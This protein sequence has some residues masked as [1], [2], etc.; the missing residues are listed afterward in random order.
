MPP[1]RKRTVR[2]KNTPGSRRRTKRKTQNSFSNDIR[3]RGSSLATSLVKSQRIPRQRRGNPSRP[4]VRLRPGLPTNIFVNYDKNVLDKR[5]LLEHHIAAGDIDPD[6]VENSSENDEDGLGTDIFKKYVD[7]AGGP[8]FKAETEMLRKHQECLRLSQQNRALCAERQQIALDSELEI[9]PIEVERNDFPKHNNFDNIPSHPYRTIFT[10]TTGSGK[11]TNMINLLIKPQYLKDYFDTIHLFS[12]NVRTEIEFEEIQKENRGDVI[13]HENF[14]EG[15]VDEIF[16]KLIK[17]AK[18][19]KNDRSMMPRVLLF[20]D[21]FAGHKEVMNSQLLVKIFF[22]SRKYSTSTWISSQRYKVVPPSLRTNAEFHV[23][24][25]QSSTQTLSIAEELSCGRFTKEHIFEA[26][27]MVSDTPFSF[28]FLNTRKRVG[29]G[30][31]RFTYQE[32]LIPPEAATEDD[33]NGED[34]PDDDRNPETS[35]VTKPGDGT[36]TGSRAKEQPKPWRRIQTP[37]L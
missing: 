16:K 26:M 6:D 29:E 35:A 33:E 18:K 9:G 34:L 32:K 1:K 3:N 13:K 10:G 22:M 17:Q 5:M 36:L 20:I 25:E 27:N 19:H 21:D 30:R 7:A 24:Y 12:P 14:D 8:L 11:T 31:F 23:I 15:E 4:A 28:I 37:R 2:F